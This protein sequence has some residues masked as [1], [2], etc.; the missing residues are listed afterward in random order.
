MLRFLN[1]LSEFH[2]FGQANYPIDCVSLPNN[3]S[4]DSMCRRCVPL[5]QAFAS[6]LSICIRVSY[7]QT[8]ISS[9]HVLQF[10]PNNTF[11]S[12]LVQ[13]SWISSLDIW[14]ELVKLSKWGM[15]ICYCRFS[16]FVPWMWEYIFRVCMVWSLKM[17]DYIS[18][19]SMGKHLFSIYW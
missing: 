2:R 5:Q 12:L 11:V 6:P 18:Y 14:Y 7:R 8:W 13:F 19:S 10:E 16:D 1:H 15:F 3:D 4:I 17:I 9:N